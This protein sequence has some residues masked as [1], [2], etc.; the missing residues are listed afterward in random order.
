MAP[1]ARSSAE[2]TA[3]WRALAMI[4]VPLV[5]LFG[6]HRVTHLERIPPA[7]AFVFTPNHVTNMD[8][9]IS[10]YVMWKAGRMPRFLAKAV[11]FRVPVFGA[12]LRASGQIPVDRASRG[13]DPLLAAGALLRDDLAVIVYPEGTLTRDPNEWPMRG[14][15][16]A[17]RLALQHDIPVI[18]MAHW[19]AQRIMPRYAT[20]SFFGI[21]RP[22]VEILIGEPVDLSAWRGRTD[23]TALAEATSALMQAITA[24]VEELRGETAPRERWD[25]AR[26]GQSEFGRP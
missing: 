17:V 3:G 6:R 2:K 1:R 5:N 20:R 14:K 7:G 12:L 24:L 23:A 21:P 13:A 15:S 25:P 4:L 16:G 8:P 19:G 11:L 18:P 22:Q 10:A 9:L 26:H